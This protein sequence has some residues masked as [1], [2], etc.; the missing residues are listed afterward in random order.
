M[1]RRDLFLTVK[2]SYRPDIGFIVFVWG[3]D[4]ETE[5][6]PHGPD[7]R[8]SKCRV[9]VEEMMSSR[10]NP[11]VL[12]ASGDIRQATGRKGHI[13]YE[14]LGAYRLGLAGRATPPS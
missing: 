8:A 2:T 7:V 12:T 14:M 5:P 9:G 6:E 11:Q 3:V 13:G 4:T 10:D 1:S